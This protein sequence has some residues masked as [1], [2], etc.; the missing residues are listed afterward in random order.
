MRDFRPGVYTCCNN[1]ECSLPAVPSIVRQPLSLGQVPIPSR[2]FPGAAGRIHEPGV[3]AGGPGMR[4][5]RAGHHGPGQRPVVAREAPASV[6]AFRDLR[7]RPAAVDPALRAASFPRWSKPRAGWK[8]R[9]R[10][11]STSTWV[12]RCG[13]SSRPGGGSALMCQMDRAVDLV[14]GG[15]RCRVDSGHGQDEARLG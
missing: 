5:P 11:L 7:K 13:K 3:P 1:G 12:A 8:R 4:R 10:R 14:S 6:R 9:E 2:F 15:R